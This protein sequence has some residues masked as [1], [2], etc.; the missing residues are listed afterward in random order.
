MGLVQVG[1]VVPGMMRVVVNQSHFL[2]N[3]QQ[4][5]DSVEQFIHSPQE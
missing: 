3:K 5:V 4:Q 2:E 1:A